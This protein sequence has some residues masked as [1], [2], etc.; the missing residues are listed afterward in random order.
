VSAILL[1]PKHLIQGPDQYE[2]VIAGGVYSRIP[3]AWAGTGPSGSGTITSIPPMS[4]KLVFFQK[5]LA[6]PPFQSS[7]PLRLFVRIFDRIGL[8]FTAEILLSVPELNV[9]SIQRFS[10]SW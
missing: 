8:V 6:F 2:I 5:E 4:P 9:V 3:G 10:N 1:A 7:E